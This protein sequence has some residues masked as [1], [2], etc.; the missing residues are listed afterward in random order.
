MLLGAASPTLLVVLVVVLAPIG[1]VA[2]WSGNCVLLALLSGWAALARRYRCADDEPH[3]AEHFVT[4]ML[5]VVSFRGALTVGIAEDGLD[6]R[7]MA[8]FRPGHPPLRIPWD[9]IQVEGEARRWFFGP[10]THLRL[11]PGGPL[12]RLPSEIWARAGRPR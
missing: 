4:G 3:G 2:I 9:A 11:G 5:G 6:L 10:V 8:V 12:L 7:V 1:S